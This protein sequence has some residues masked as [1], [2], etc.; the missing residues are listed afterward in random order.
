MV[1]VGKGEAEGW[2][3]VEAEEEGKDPKAAD[4]MG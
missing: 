4:P 3:N 2:E 1:E